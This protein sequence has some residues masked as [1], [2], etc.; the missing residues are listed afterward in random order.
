MNWHGKARALARDVRGS[1]AL[2]IALGTMVFL[3][4]GAIAIELS[5]LMALHTEVQQAAEAAALAGAKELDFTDAGLTAAEDAA[6]NAVTNFQNLAADAGNVVEIDTVQFLWA[7][8]PAGQTN[9]GLYTTT[10]ASEARY[11]RTVTEPRTHVSG[12]LTAFLALW[13][14]DGNEAATNI[15]AGSAVAGRTAVACRTLPLMMCNPAEGVNPVTQAFGPGPNGGGW[16][17]FGEFLKAHPE[18]TRRQYRIKWIGPGASIGP[19]V[20][21]LLEPRFSE[22]NGAKGVEDELALNIPSFCVALNGAT[23]DPDIKTGQAQTVVDGLNVRFDMYSGNWK[24]EKNSSEYSPAPNVTKGMLTKGNACNVDTKSAQTMGTDYFE[25]PNDDCFSMDPTA[26]AAAGCY[27]FGAQD[28][29]ATT[30]QGNKGFGGRYGNG[31]WDIKKYFSINHPKDMQG[32]QIKAAIWN[33]LLAKETNVYNEV[34]M[35]KPPAPTQNGSG[36]P[37]SRYTVY[38]WEID[39]A[40]NIP[41]SQTKQGQTPKEE[42]R[43]QCNKNNIA[44]GDRRFLYI[45]VVNCQDQAEAI[46]AHGTVPA[47]EFAEGFLTEPADHNGQGG[48]NEKGAI[49][50][51]VRRTIEQGSASNIVLRDV[52][53][54]Y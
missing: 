11:I 9:Y 13:T 3:P 29:V 41:G 31:K 34:G 25:L 51:E 20:F 49:Y 15:V 44:S 32:G 12:L 5:S 35:P 37:V 50:I 6:K 17:K 45:A 7:L 42:G 16:T 48:Q 47:L 26:A 19:G 40:S 46:A 54:L 30:P 28:G 36:Q 2:Y 39:K 8:P 24:N 52:I 22:K 38:R 21:G 14:G 1:V 18:W 33:E 27:S 23:I 10:K 4:V 53:Q 43:P